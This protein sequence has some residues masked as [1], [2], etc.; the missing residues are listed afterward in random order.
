MLENSAAARDVR[1]LLHGY[2]ELRNQR[3][4][5]PTVITGGKGIYVYDENGTPYIEGAAG[6]W[7]T[8]LGFD[9]PEL[10]EAA[11][12]QLHKLPYYHTVAYKSVNPA[13]DLA[14][15]LAALV[16]IR[17]SKIHF[18][19][20]GSEANDFLIKFVRFYYNAIGK[21]AKKK[22]I[23]RH[24]S[25]HGATIMAAS[26]SGIPANHRYFD[27]PLPGILHATEPHYFH[28]ALAGETPAEFADRLALQLEEMILKE[29]ADTIAAFIAE[30]ITGAGGVVIPPEPY[31]AKI[32]AILKHYDIFFLADEVITGFHRTGNFWGCETMD[33]Q[34]DAMTLAKGLT[35]GYQPLAAI[36]LCDKIYQGME[37]GSAEIRYFGHGTTYSGHPVG[38][39]VALKVLDLIKERDIGGHV[40]KVSR[41]FAQ[42]LNAFNDHPLVGEVRCT[43]LMGAVEFVSDKKTNTFFDPVG[44][45]AKRVKEHAEEQYKLI[46]RALPSGDACAFS[47][48]VIITEEEIDEMF[49]RFGRALDDITLQVS[50]ETGGRLP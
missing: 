39:A 30:P 46:C 34:P 28:H 7:C 18:A 16:P 3:E 43:G 41:R 6:M 31:Y 38:C 2:V 15:R 19:L 23:S 37:Q 25:Y 42:R 13:I 1:H 26:L 48:P 27:L 33:I 44:S 20:S 40:A 5:G 29:G 4:R 24:N 8:L 12:E 35:S 47:P 11:T 45:F 14:E 9:E 49:D 17:D 50:R 22:I 10:V 21:T 36:V 32:Q